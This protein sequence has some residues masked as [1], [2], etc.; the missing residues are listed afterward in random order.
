MFY[1]YRNM[2][3][4]YYNQSLLSYCSIIIPLWMIKRE[5]IDGGQ[6]GQEPTGSD[7]IES[8]QQTD[9]VITLTVSVYGL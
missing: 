9:D 6:V 4:E 3:K 7:H 2:I 5:N 1:T 8:Q